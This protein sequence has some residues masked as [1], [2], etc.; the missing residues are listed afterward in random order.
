MMDRKEVKKM[1]KKMVGIL[2]CVILIMTSVSISAFNEKP[3]ILQT[4]R[5]TYDIILEKNGERI[6][7]VDPCIWP[8]N[9]YG[10]VD[11]PAMCPYVAPYDQMYIID[12][13]FPGTTIELDP[14]LDNFINIVTYPGGLLGGEVHTFDATL[15]MAVFGTGDLTGFS[16][17]L[18]VPVSL[19]V[20]IGPR[21]PGDPIQLFPSEIFQLYGEIFGDP[22]FCIIRILA[23]S[24]YG[25][26]S[27]GQ[28]TLTELPSEDFN[29]DSYF[30]ISYQIEFEGCPGSI[31]EGMAG[32]TTGVTR[33]Q[34]GTEV[35]NTPPN[36]PAINGPTSGKAGIDHDYIFSAT[37]PDGDDVSYFIKWGDGSITSWTA[38][39]T[40]GSSFTEVHTWTAK[41]EYTIEAKTK[42][43]HGAESGWST[44]LI[45][46]SK[47]KKTEIKTNNEMDS[48]MFCDILI[49][50]TA[51]VQVIRDSF[52]LGFGKCFYMKVNLENDGSLEISSITNPSNGVDLQGS[53][54]VHLIGFSGYY[55]N[56]LKT[57]ID[58]KALLTIWG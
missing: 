17:H 27:P 58:G 57:R 34:Q 42:D 44:L 30:D 48:M 43:N 15:E 7:I 41:D 50:G 47:S 10:T 51:T 13:L 45:S 36:K 9:G 39:Q 31:L 21:N 12:G 18:S 55:N 14:T 3:V 40:S 24:G 32:T 2:V 38:F 20:H 1:K 37:D 54:Q 26:P 23:G 33:L 6:F 46:M 52:V 35:I 5:L 19:E 25:L 28:F 4:T 53:H 29:V 49:K 8:D 16:R 11:L 22:D 56:I